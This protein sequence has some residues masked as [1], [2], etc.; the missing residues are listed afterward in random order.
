MDDGLL[1]AVLAA[2][3]G[4]RFGGGKLDADCAGRPLGAWA[5][6]AAER[7]GLQPGIIVT[8]P[9][10]PAFA[11]AAHRWTCVTNP[12][13]GRGLG[14]SLA[15]AANHAASSGAGRL[16]VLLADMPL[17]EPSMLREL[18]GGETL[19]AARHRGGRPGVPAVFAA[20]HLPLLQSLDGARGAGPILA[21]M[22]GLRLVDAAQ[23][24]L[25]DVD[26]AAALVHAAHVLSRRESG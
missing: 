20:A 9:Q 6:A 12:D 17:L 5:L 2:G 24:T 7:A 18:A 10:V 25:A 15:I 11:Q 4:R 21:A 23:G 3:A 16:L 14:S 22:P 26:D 1:V 19:A 8:P 13:P